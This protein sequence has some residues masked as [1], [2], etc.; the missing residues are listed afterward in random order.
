MSYTSAAA[1]VPHYLKEGLST[2]NHDYPAANVCLHVDDEYEGMHIPKDS[3]IFLATWAIHHS[4][5][6]FEDHERFNPDRYLK[7]DK[8]ANDYAGAADWAS[9][10][11][12]GYGAGR[13]ICPGIHLAER[14][15]WRIA[16]KLLWAYEFAEPLDPVTGQVKPL[17]ADAYINGILISPLPFEV[18]ITP[19]SAK[20][21]ARIK[22]EK[23]AALDFLRQYE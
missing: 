20:H 5:A 22:T 11:H 9:R 15:M 19:R 12:Y 1:G 21:V 6:E 18:R 2:L 7:F 14:N 4:D 23:A 10:D 16:A 8:L 3:M 17:D 13:R